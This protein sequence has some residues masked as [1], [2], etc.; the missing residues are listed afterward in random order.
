MKISKDRL[1]AFTDAIVAIAATIM[2]LELT[3]PPQTNW[4]SLFAQ[5]PTFIAYL[6]SFSL[7][8]IG[9][10]NYY[11]GLDKVDYVGVKEFIWNG[12]WVFVLTLIPFVTRWVSE[13]PDK[14]LPEFLYCLMM[15]LWALIF[16]L[17][18]HQVIKDFPEQ[19]KEPT[20]S[21]WIK[22]TSF[23]CH[24]L[25]MIVAFIMPIFSFL[26]IAFVVII[27]TIGLV[28]IKED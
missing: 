9:W 16:Q 5:W 24:I 22:Y 27:W 4:Q 19:N 7:I 28:R 21:G 1:A 11:R 15:F 14:T 13:H 23:S 20:Y 12:I 25:G 18:E 10:L 8:F 6:I 2:V 17:M 26:F 3:T